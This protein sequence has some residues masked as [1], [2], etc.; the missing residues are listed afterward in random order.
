MTGTPSSMRIL[1]HHSARRSKLGVPTF[2]AHHE[3]PEAHGQEARHP[4]SQSAGRELLLH[5]AIGPRAI[6]G[7]IRSANRGI[8]RPRS[9]EVRAFA[10][11]K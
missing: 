5:D 1:H 3:F 11:W 8:S 9:S 7:P 10:A 4:R 2:C 6:F